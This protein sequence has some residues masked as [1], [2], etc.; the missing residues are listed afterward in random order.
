M[1]QV[2]KK[3]GSFL[4]G[5]IIV[6]VLMWVGQQTPSGGAQVVFA[7]APQFIPEAPNASPQLLFQGQLSNPSTGQPV[8]DGAY[9]MTFNLYNT[10]SGGTPLWTEAKQI[11]ATSGLFATLLGN[12]TPLN[13]DHFN[14]Q[15]LY[16]GIQVSGDPEAAPRQPL[17]YSAYAIRADRATLADNAERL[18]GL[19]GGDFIRLG[20]DGVVAFG[21]IDAD[22]SRISGVR[23]SSGRAGSGIYEITIDG[24]DYNLNQFATVVTPI[25]NDQCPGAVIAK[26]GSS[27]G[28]LNVYLYNLSSQIIGCKFHFVT[29]ET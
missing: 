26:T 25:D 7:Q 12:A 3:T 21:I 17:G 14:G 22:G 28:K 1:L 13:V 6:A 9:A 19:D 15:Q 23:F 2:L 18:D 27:N 20:N 24:E 11:S 8:V 16:L 29:F 10:A 5:G 4:L